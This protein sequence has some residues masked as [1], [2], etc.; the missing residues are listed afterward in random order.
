MESFCLE[1]GRWQEDRGGSPRTQVNCS[2]THC[3][4][5][6]LWYSGGRFF[7]LVDG[8]DPVVSEGPLSG[9]ALLSQCT[10]ALPSNAVSQYL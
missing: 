8:P 7:L 4:Y 10:M 3:I 6:N 5:E 1:P 2:E 9:A